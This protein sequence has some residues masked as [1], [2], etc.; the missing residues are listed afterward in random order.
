[1]PTA[2]WS[3]CGCAAACRP[4]PR[5]WRWAATGAASCSRT[6]TSTCWCCCPAPARSTTRP[7]TRCAPRSAASSP[8]AGTSAWRSARRC[9]RSTSASTEARNDVTV[10]TAMIESRFLA[11]ATAAVPHV[12]ARH[13]RGDRS[14]GL[15]AR[16][17][18]RDAPAP[19]QVRG[20]AVRAGAQLQGEPRRPARPAGGDLGGA[21]GG[22]RAQLGR[23]A[24]PRA[25]S[26]R[27]KLR[28]LQRHEGTIKLIRARLHA[29][30]NRRED[31]LVFDLQTAVAESFGTQARQGAAHRPRC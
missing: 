6:P 11:G 29:I 15:P 30:A 5:W 14:A 23:A 31:R 21:R 12:Q 19:R 1:M 24:R 28:R 18:A 9:A 8:R 25:C 27:T 2:R 17:D 20:H 3:S 22:P 10:Q 13:R 26:R 4:A 16:Q 7:T